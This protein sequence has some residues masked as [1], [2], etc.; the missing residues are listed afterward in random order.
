L[1]NVL[2][3]FARVCAFQRTAFQAHFEEQMQCYGKQLLIN[4]IDQRGNERDV[5]E[6][7]ETQVRL[8]NNPD[9]RYYFRQTA[10]LNDTRS[11]THMLS[12]LFKTFLSRSYIPFDFHEVCK[13]MKYEN[14]QL[15]TNESQPYMDR[16]R[17]DTLFVP[18]TNALVLTMSILFFF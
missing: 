17:Y 2:T 3:L 14:L 8:L 16:F 18:E 13:N 9:I 7:Y 6:A 4:L 1:Y 5:G 11:I 10:A 15:L 12:S